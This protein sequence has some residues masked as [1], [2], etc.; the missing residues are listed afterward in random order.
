MM[1]KLLTYK[2][3]AD[4]LGV[5]EG[6]LQDIVAENKLPA[7]KIGGVYT[8]FKLDDL[9]SFRRRVS[10]EAGQKKDRDSVIDRVKDFFYFNDFYILC[11]MAVAIILY[12]IFK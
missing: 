6:E 4:Y 12:L 8:R 1:K 7:Y 2:E 3:A 11:G 5:S 10:L 9:S